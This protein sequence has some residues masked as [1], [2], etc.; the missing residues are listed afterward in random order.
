[1]K[2]LPEDQTDCEE[3]ISAAPDW[4][5]E[6]TLDPAAAI[7][8]EKKHKANKI[9]RERENAKANSMPAAINDFG[10]WIERYR[11]SAPLEDKPAE[12]LIDEFMNAL[13]LG[14]NRDIEDTYRLIHNSLLSILPTSTDARTLADRLLKHNLA[15]TIIERSELKMKEDL[16]PRPWLVPDWLPIG[17]VALFAGQGG[18]GKSTLALQLA[19]SVVTGGSRPTLCFDGGDDAALNFNG[20]PSPVVYCT[21][22]DE[23]DEVAR[24][25]KAIGAPPEAIENRFHLFDL[26]ATGP[27][28]EPGKTG[29]R[30]TST[31]GA[32][33]DTAD[34][35][36]AYCE[37]QNPS[38]LVLDPLAA[39]YACNEND[40]GL[41][42]QFMASL[43]ANAHRLKMAVLLIAHPPK[44]T[45][46]I[47]SGSTDWPASARAVLSL[48]RPPDW[49][50]EEGE[51]QLRLE[52][53]S[54]GPLP[55]QPFTLARRP[56]SGL[57]PWEAKQEDE[58]A[59][60]DTRNR[61]REAR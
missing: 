57:Q 7:E 27:L 47:Y 60:A 25:L 20:K 9:G 43:N 29:S 4:V 44:D 51:S 10:R 8:R 38:L 35:L 41:V 53:S 30:H 32:W 54:Y 24:R 18:A 59:I 58:G 23:P 36:F 34:V 12:K 33:T 11:K 14:V 31:M 26:A 13:G 46:A 40:R 48:G 39:A 45:A 19:A 56:G 1:M 5:D 28:W 50:G 55:K 22:E 37:G 42:R 17:R 49:K 6:D 52:K 61:G 3:R 21:W 2:N 15:I 16:P